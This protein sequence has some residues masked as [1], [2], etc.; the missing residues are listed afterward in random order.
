MRTEID[1]LV[2]QNFVLYK[3]DQPPL[4]NDTEWKLEYELD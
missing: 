4:E 1:I 3:E 2:L